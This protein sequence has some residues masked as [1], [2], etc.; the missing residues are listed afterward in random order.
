MSRAVRACG[1]TCLSEGT[2]DGPS[3]ATLARSRSAVPRRGSIGSESR[4][5]RLGDIV[6][7]WHDTWVRGGSFGIAVE[8]PAGTSGYRRCYTGTTRVLSQQL[9]PRDILRF[10][11][12]ETP[13]SDHIR[14]PTCRNLTFQSK[15]L[16]KSGF[17]RRRPIWDSIISL[18][19]VI[20]VS[21]QW[22]SDGIY[23]K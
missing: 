7:G 12:R 14:D 10:T 15:K 16:E 13:A 22:Q 6:R 18:D 17:S 4:S 20:S 21:W 9:A 3:A 19:A 23:R 8:Q 1:L 5:P 11:V 2:D